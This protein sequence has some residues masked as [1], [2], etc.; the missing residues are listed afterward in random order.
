MMKKISLILSC[1]LLASTAVYATPCEEVMQMIAEKIKGNGVKEFTLE[2]IDKGAP[3]DKKIVGVC[4]EGTKDIIYY[5][6]KPAEAASETT[7]VVSPEDT[8]QEVSET[9][10]D[11]PDTT[12][13]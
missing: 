13:E 6:G 2:A 8:Q 12:A 7:V 5:K 11:T 4:A 1:L 10:Q 3:T 9:K